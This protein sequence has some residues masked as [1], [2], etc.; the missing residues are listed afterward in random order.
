MRWNKSMLS[1]RN[2]RFSQRP[3][4]AFLDISNIL[5]H[6]I[7][8]RM[9]PNNLRHNKPNIA[10][11]FSIKLIKIIKNKINNIIT[12]IHKIKFQT[13]L[14]RTIKKI[15]ITIITMLKYYI[16]L[17]NCRIC[18]WYTYWFL[19]TKNQGNGGRTSW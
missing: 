13:I 19:T 16:R 18:W 10:P 12:I 7:T 9:H 5:R 15:I 8:K 4:D 11:K 14:S 6:K 3:W 1:L 17:K 2:I